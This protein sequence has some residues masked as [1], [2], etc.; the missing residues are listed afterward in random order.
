MAAGGAE[1]WLLLSFT[2]PAL[3]TTSHQ[4][5]SRRK[6]Q[7]PPGYLTRLLRAFFRNGCQTKLRPS[8]AYAVMSARPVSK[9]RC[10][11]SS[12]RA[13][14]QVRWR[15]N[16]IAYRQLQKSRRSSQLPV[17]SSVLFYLR[18]YLR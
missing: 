7:L 10:H 12:R 5:R 15:S 1:G 11:E 6:R 8:F 3:N 9:V 2:L 16:G 13:T 17:L 18:S 4:I 14:S